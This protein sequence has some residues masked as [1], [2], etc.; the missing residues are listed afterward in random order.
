[1]NSSNYLVHCPD[2]LTWSSLVTPAFCHIPRL[3]VTNCT[4]RLVN[5]HY[6]N[7]TKHYHVI[8]RLKLSY[9]C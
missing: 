1:M 5:A 9:G 4:L 2:E 8:A 6:V 3:S 7:K